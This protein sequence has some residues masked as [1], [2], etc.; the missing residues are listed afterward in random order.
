MTAIRLSYTMRFVCPAFLGNAEQN[1]QWRTPPM[2]ALLRQW[3]R[4]AYAADKR[5]VVDVKGM[6]K[7]EGQLFGAAADAGASNKSRVRIRLDQWDTGRLRRWEPTGNVWHPEVRPNGRNVG[8]DLYLGYGPLDYD[9]KNRMTILKRN[10]AIQA[11]ES[12]VFHIALASDTPDGEAARIAKTL[13]LMNLYGTLGGR[14]RNG[15]GSFVLEGGP[16]L[17]PP[18]VRVLRP[19]PEALKLDWPH[20]I[21]RDLKGALVW[22]TETFSDWK[23]AMRRLAEI[24]IGLRRQFKFAPGNARPQERHWLSYPVTHHL[25]WG[26]NCRLPNSLRF[27]LRPDNRDRTK[28]RGIIF[29]VPCLPPSEFQPQRQTIESVWKRVHDFLDAVQQLSRIPD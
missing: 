15:W 20:A 8:S 1:G 19:W 16:A 7:A 29:H 26:G 13:A 11:D 23:T 25:V 22:E 10:A 3:W 6:R 14:S 24:K 21:G 18:D 5:F 17:P 28:L 12:A 2:K 27:K 4:V 9:N